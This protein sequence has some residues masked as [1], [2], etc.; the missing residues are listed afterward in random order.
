MRRGRI[1]RGSIKMNSRE[2]LT[3]NIQLSSIALKLR[4]ARRKKE[5]TIQQVAKEICVLPAQL[6]KWETDKEIPGKD[7]LI[8][9]SKYYNIDLP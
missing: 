8:K 4:A 1:F 7:Y 5:K 9:L 2:D 6:L 3:I